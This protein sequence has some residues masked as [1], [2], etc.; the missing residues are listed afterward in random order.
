MSNSSRFS[1]NSIQSHIKSRFKFEAR[2]AYNSH[3]PAGNRSGSVRHA[4]AQPQLDE[5]ALANAKEQAKK[6]TDEFVRE[7]ANKEW[8]LNNAKPSKKQ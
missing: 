6:N 7:N 8:V 5:Q 2:S 1:Q 4:R 3:M